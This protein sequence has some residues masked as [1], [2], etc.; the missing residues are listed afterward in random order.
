MSRKGE[1]IRKR[2]DGRWEARY[3]KGR[4]TNGTIQYGYLYG[5]TYREVKEKKNKK[6]SEIPRQILQPTKSTELPPDANVEMVSECWKTNVRHTVKDSTY[7]NY[8]TILH[9]QI[10]PIIGNC[11]VKD[12]SNKTI[13][14]F[15]QAKIEQGF[16][17][18]TIHVTLSVLKNILKFA[19]TAGIYPAEDLKF[20]HVTGTG[21]DIKIM[22]V[23]DYRILEEYL[24][25]NLNSF[26]YGILL[27]M[28]TGIRVGELSGLRWEDIDF[29]GKKICIRRTVT[30]IKNLDNL[31]D[32][33]THKI[34]KTILH[35]GT[36]K[37]ANSAREIPLPDK[38]LEIGHTL[39]NKRENYILTGTEKCMEPRIIQR[40]YAILL[41]ECQIPPIKIHS[42]RHQFSCRWVE[43]GFDT[44]SLSEILGHTSV[45]TTLD[46]YVHIR[47]DTKRKYMNQLMEN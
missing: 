37:T 4:D 13:W 47:S 14:Q 34:N 3:I 15:I 36:P 45:R 26:A 22:E 41:K 28:H 25:R 5:K 11:T 33:M 44:K 23:D 24:I 39:I 21:N 18:G 38:L 46:L 32:P 12:I 1:N 17:S 43:Q 27:C 40:K 7:S 42:L 9:N 8:E 30:R 19:Q 10:L 35:I 29:Q 20:P 31:P 2:K 6:I 16:A